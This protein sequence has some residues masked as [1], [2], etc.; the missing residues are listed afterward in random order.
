VPPLTRD[1][2]A[3]RDDLLLEV[4]RR[5]SLANRAFRLECGG[6]ELTHASNDLRTAGQDISRTLEGRDWPLLL[7]EVRPWGYGFV[8]RAGGLALALGGV[9]M[10]A[11]RSVIWLSVCE[12]HPTNA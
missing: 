12:L 1:I 9:F 6:F 5:L 8:A 11:P 7:L 4:S 3:A 10:D 2:E